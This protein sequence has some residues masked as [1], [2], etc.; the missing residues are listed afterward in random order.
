LDDAQIDAAEGARD[1]PA[2]VA[3]VEAAEGWYRAALGVPD[4]RVVV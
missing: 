2:L 4:A 1:W 3:A